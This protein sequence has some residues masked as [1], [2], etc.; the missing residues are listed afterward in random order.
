MRRL[1]LSWRTGREMYAMLQD[2][3]A[4]PRRML[5]KVAHPPASIPCQRLY[6]TLRAGDRLVPHEG[7]QAMFL[8]II[9][10]VLGYTW[11]SQVWR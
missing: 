3:G 2:V 5:S 8:F 9:C 1:W 4:D 6:S 11:A 7:Q 10:N